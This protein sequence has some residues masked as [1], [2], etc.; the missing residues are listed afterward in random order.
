MV[1]YVVG[2][3]QVGRVVGLYRE[4]ERVEHAAQREL[5][6]VIVGVD[7][8]EIGAA[9]KL[10]AV[11]HDATPV[12]VLL[13]DCHDLRVLFGIAVGDSARVVLRPVVDDEDLARVRRREKRIDAPAHVV[14]RVVAGNDKRN[15]GLRLL[16]A[17]ILVHLLA[18]RRCK[19][20]PSI[21]LADW[22]FPFHT[23]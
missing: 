6:E 4:R 19:H 10:D 18:P 21:T 1:I 11:V 20:R 22:V 3:E 23:K 15:Q 8:F 12:R 16:A 9:G 17:V 5:V 7:D 2:D 14:G 13:V